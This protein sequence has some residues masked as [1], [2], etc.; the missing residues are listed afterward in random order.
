MEFFDLAI[1]CVLIGIIAF[2][3]RRSYQET[4]MIS[5]WKDEIEKESRPGGT[6]K[7]KDYNEFKTKQLTK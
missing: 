3:F 5:E 2:Y 1:P 4:K 7:E 6:E